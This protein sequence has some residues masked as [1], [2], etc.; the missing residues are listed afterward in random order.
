MHWIQDSKINHTLKHW[1]TFHSHPYIFFLQLASLLW[2]WNARC[3]FLHFTLSLVFS[4]FTCFSTKYL[5][6]VPHIKGWKVR[7]TIFS[8]WEAVAEKLM[9]AGHLSVFKWLKSMYVS[10]YILPSTLSLVVTLVSTSVPSKSLSTLSQI[11]ADYPS[12]L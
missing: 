2:T 3:Q 8:N 6:P 9:Q 4:T 1:L 7:M 11:R 12:L 5:L 10:T